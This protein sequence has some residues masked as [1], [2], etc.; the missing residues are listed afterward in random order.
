MKINPQD[1]LPLTQ[2]AFH[3]LVALAERERH[4]Y[5]IIQEVEQRTDGKLR[6]SPGTLYGAIKRMLDEGLIAETGQRPDRQLGAE[7]RRYYR[8]TGLGRRV[9]AA[10]TERL[11]K[12]VSQ[13]IAS[14]LPK[15]V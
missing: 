11:S 15:R 2:A 4:G 13:A 3:I 8:L 12:L 10:E 7:R 6:L 14:L 9:A 1:F 5:G